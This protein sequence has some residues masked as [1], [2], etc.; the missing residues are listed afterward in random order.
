MSTTPSTS[1]A[2]HDSGTPPA[3]PRRAARRWLWPALAVAGCGA[4]IALLVYGVIARS[5]DTT[6]DDSL[7]RG[8]P[9]EAPGF[10]LAVLEPGRLGPRLTPVLR[11]ALADGSVALAELRGR[12]V[13][14]NLWASWCVPCRQEAPLLQRTWRA[15]R[16][17]GVLFVGL[18]MQDLTGDARDFLDEF[19]IDY[20]NVR[21]R[22]D[23]VARRYGVTG[24][25]E[26][27][28]I[29]PSGRIVGHVIGVSSAADLRAGIA[30]TAT[31]RPVRARR[32]G[33]QG[34]TR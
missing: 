26:T 20:L 15:V 8:V 22:G 9:P 18:D 12:R 6:I 3:R 11:P 14:L 25:P 27:F 34:A 10:E 28:F 4:L 32:A 30:A 31:G 5:P 13:V 21:D 2:S 17:R 19:R 16:D 7:A 29:A 24:V 23:A 33:A 1:P